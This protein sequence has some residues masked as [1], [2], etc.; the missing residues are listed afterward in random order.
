MRVTASEAFFIVLGF[1]SS[2]AKLPVA[3][4]FGDGDQLPNQLAETMVL[5][6]LLARSLHR[7]ASWN[8]PRHGL[9]GHRAGKRM[10]G[11]VSLGALL[12]AVAGRLAAL[13]EAGH[14]GAGAHL[15]DVGELVQQLIAL[16]HED[17]K[18]WRS[19]H[20]S[21]DSSI[22]CQNR[23]KKALSACRSAISSLSCRAPGKD[24]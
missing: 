16:Q 6:E 20:G 3:D 14:K 9:A 10:G 24:P 23:Y 13:A 2:L 5:V 4:L 12:G 15:T 18:V 22:H 7:G 17:L 11:A 1:R 8:D 21:P 19:G